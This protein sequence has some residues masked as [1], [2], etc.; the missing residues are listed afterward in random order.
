LHRLPTGQGLLPCPTPFEV[1]R[2]ASLNGARVAGFSPRF[3]KLEKDS[4]ADL[5]LLD[6]VR[7]TFPYIDPEVHPVEALVYLAQAGHVDTVMING[8]VELEGG[9]FVKHD[10]R[11]LGQELAALAAR[12]P[13]PEAQA[14]DSLLREV[15]PHVAR[16]YAAWREEGAV[17]PRYAVNSSIGER[18]GSS[19]SC[20]RVK[21]TP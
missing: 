19:R 17:E 10:E 15:K 6:Y 11:A 14:L 4:P 5:V 9:R 20:Q 3:G 7:M 8:E 1:F 13:S 16:Y 12:P 2:M 18:V 21:A